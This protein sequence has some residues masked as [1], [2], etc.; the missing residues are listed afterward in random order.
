[1]IGVCRGCACNTDR[2][3]EVSKQKPVALCLSC[4]SAW[5]ASPDKK[6][7]DYYAEEAPAT[8]RDGKTYAEVEAAIAGIYQRAFMDFLY[9]LQRERV[10]HGGKQVGA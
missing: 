9:Q 10:V 3:W 1:M 8:R 7:A 5:V 6:R 4:Q 2:T